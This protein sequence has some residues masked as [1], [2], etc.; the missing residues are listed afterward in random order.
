MTG[1]LEEQKV[2]AE[3]VPNISYDVQGIEIDGGRYTLIK[4]FGD[5]QSPSK[6]VF[7]C[8]D[9]MRR[10]YVIKVFTPN[11]QHAF[12]CEAEAN[13]RLMRNGRTHQHLISMVEAVGYGA[14][15]G[16]SLY[17]TTFYHYSYIVIPFA[18]Y[19]SLLEVYMKA[20]VKGH[21]FSI[22]LKLYFFR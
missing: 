2:E 20:I 8:E 22:H 15:T 11:E 6:M 3:A 14:R 17:G 21:N 13:L 4:R 18:K 5:D 16:V 7:L 10:E 1:V 12:A 9:S 19:G